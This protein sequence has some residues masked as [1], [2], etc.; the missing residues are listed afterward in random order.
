VNESQVF[1]NALKLA[2]PA[3][4]AAYLNKACAGNP[5]LRADVEALLRVYAKDPNFLEQ[6]A[7]SLFGT[8]DEPPTSIS[9]S[10]APAKPGGTEQSGRLLAG[11]YRLLEQIGEGG[12]GAVWMAKQTEPVK[13]LVAVKLIKPGMDS[14]QMLARFEAERQA[15]ALMDHPNIAK[16]FDAATTEGEPGGISSGSPFFVMELVKGVPITRFCD[17]RRLTPRQRLELFVP[18]CQAIQH[19]HQKGIIHRDLK[20]SN[21]LV[22]LYDDRPVPKVIDFGVAKAAGSP[23]TEQTLQTGFGAIVGTLEYMSPEQ[24]GFNQLDVDTRTDIYSLGVLLYELLAGSPPF[25]RKELEKAGLLEMLRV[26]REKEPSKPSIKLST[27]VGLPTLAENRG[28][29]PKRLTALVRG[30]LDWIVMKA[31]EK[32][33]N[34]RYES[35]N[36]LAMDVQRYLNDEPVQ[37]CPP[38]AW[39]RLRKFTRRNKGPVLAA[40]V[41]V[42]LL[43][44]GIVGT[45][46]GLIRAL[47]AEQQTSEALTQVTAE[48]AKTQAA[49]T[50]E[51]AAQTKSREALDVL[52][53]D[54]VER[55]FAK[56]PEL[57][58]AEKAFLRKVLGFYEAI[59]QQLGETPEARLLRGKGYFKVAYLRALL[60]ELVTAEEAYSQALS[61]L[62][63]LPAIFPDRLG[64][65]EV[66]AHTYN[67]LGIVRAELGKGAEAE[68]ALRKALAIR[69]KLTDD[70]PKVAPSRLKLAGSYHDLA[71][72]LVNQN[73]LGEAG[74]A[75]RQA[76]DLKEKL[77][78]E[79]GAEPALL[80]EL[81]RSRSGLGQL[82][83]KQG[84]YEEAEKLYH[85][86][87]DVQEKHRA[88]LPTVPKLRREAADSY[89]GLAI[90]LAEL[91][92]EAEAETAFQK[93][94]DLQK[95][96]TE[97]F[98]KVQMYRRQL[99]ASY[100]DLSKM[101]ERQRKF[102]DAEEACRQAV[103]LWEKLVAEG[104]TIPENHQLLA[105]TLTSLGNLLRNQNKLA[106]AENAYRKALPHQT[107]LAEDHPKVIDYRLELA[108]TL[109]NLALV[110]HQRQASP[111]GVLLLEQARSNL[112]AGLEVSPRHPVCRLNYRKALWLLAKSYLVLADHVRL[113]MTAD[114]MA[115]FAYEPVND[116]FDAACM[117]SSCVTLAS[118]D[119][120]LTEAGR[121]EMVQHYADRALARLRQAV[122][123]GFNDAARMKQ[124]PSLEPLR[125]RADFKKLLADLEWQPK[126]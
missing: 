53:D 77:V 9:L 81:A 118:K 109:V 111:A 87:L 107:K 31:L 95:K 21:V 58:E 82:L 42:L 126:E 41:I 73:N 79:A 98:P 57:E 62:E 35:A 8:V 1:A 38:S 26:I 76:I 47:A 64:Y 119:T 16:V 66:V 90:V 103:P 106:D 70:F 75:Y 80:Q 10:D 96:L 30:E 60:G 51:T 20:P 125:G 123:C 15:L 78:A 12:M 25:S 102:A 23:L 84:K 56:Q 55:L 37:A 19:A 104:G 27:A 52:T 72:L 28:T 71:V 4:Q 120:G 101:L 36:S 46:I 97:D 83:R 48:Q 105:R 89:H 112:Q 93:A 99:A 13:R 92:K 54:V 40:G 49:L 59:T 2:T 45:T 39:Y 100:D 85:L 63:P 91:K 124:N 7:A 6:P 61:L 86:A 122:E 74:T 88:E 50:A 116:T 43:A 68:T 94:L 3:E 5:Q 114:D 33:R 14:K 113:A 44:A 34:R 67:R 11:R 17:E 115:R 110:L 22:A 117:M 69:K 18:V 108:T 29:E 24:A 121:K 32:D 65:R